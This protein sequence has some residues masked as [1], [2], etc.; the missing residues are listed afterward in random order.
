MDKK[1][2][3]RAEKLTSL[4]KKQRY[5]EKRVEAAVAK[6]KIYK[7]I[8]SMSLGEIR[9]E[10]HKRGFIETISNNWSSE[11]YKMKDEELLERAEPDNEF[12]IALL[13]KLLGEREPIFL[14]I[15]RTSAYSIY[16]HVPVMNK[17]N[18]LYKNFATKDGL[19]ELVDNIKKHCSKTVINHPRTYIVSSENFKRFYCDYKLTIATSVVQFLHYKKDI[20]SMFAENGT[21]D[22]KA[23]DWAFQVNHCEKLRQNGFFQVFFAGYH[24]V[25]TT[26]RRRLSVDEYRIPRWLSVASFE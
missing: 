5:Y 11:L 16:Q 3:K 13:T 21:L 10:L 23:L 7:V 24:S 9:S 20:K 6:G 22:L 25:F 17:I 12:E 15:N 14:W 2:K 1:L 26:K 8:G 4:E 19:C 18:I